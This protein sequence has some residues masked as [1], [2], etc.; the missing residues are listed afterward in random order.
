MISVNIFYFSIL[1]SSYRF[2]LQKISMDSS[3]PTLELVL[4]LV[5]HTDL[6]SQ[7]GTA[8]PLAE[9]LFLKS[10]QTVVRFQSSDFQKLMWRL[11]WDQLRNN[12]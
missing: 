11:P 1:T 2:L 8:L 9:I 3:L 5:S 4:Q 6:V 10:E 12:P 7:F